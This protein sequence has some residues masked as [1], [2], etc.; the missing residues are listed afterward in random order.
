MVEIHAIYRRHSFHTIREKVT[1]RENGTVARSIVFG[2]S[3]T[4][5]MLPRIP[6]N[7]NRKDTN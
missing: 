6:T 4:Y 7:N 5:A 3:N 1:R 2:F